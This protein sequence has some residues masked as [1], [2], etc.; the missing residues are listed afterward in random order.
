M[1]VTFKR[2]GP[3]E[4]KNTVMEQKRIIDN[5]KDGLLREKLLTILRLDCK[6][7]RRHENESVTLA[8]FISPMVRLN[9]L[10]KAEVIRRPGVEE[11]L[12]LSYFCEDFWVLDQSHTERTKDQGLTFY[13]FSDRIA[14]SL[15]IEYTVF[16]IYTSV[17][18][19]LAQI[20][21]SMLVPSTDTIVFQSMIYSDKLLVLCE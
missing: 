17:V 21:R 4:S 7:A 18:F 5:E 10:D 20:L 12:D 11:D 1:V 13:T 16:T 3:P 15:V 2:A 9:H 19:L 6:K 14:P 8:E